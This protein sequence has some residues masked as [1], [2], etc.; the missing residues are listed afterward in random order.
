MATNTSFLTNLRDKFKKGLTTFQNAMLG[1]PVQVMQPESSVQYQYP[2]QR[3]TDFMNNFRNNEDLIKNIK[4]SPHYQG[5]TDDELF[6]RVAQ[7]QNFGLKE[8][9]DEQ[10]QWGIKLPRANNEYD[11][12]ALEG[13]YLNVYQPKLQTGTANEPRQGGIINDFITGARENYN[14]GFNVDNWGQKKNFATRLGEGL[15]TL[16]R[17]ADSAPGRGLIAGG[18][19]GALGGS[20]A[21]MTAY[22]LSAG[23][24]RQQN[25][26]QDQLYRQRLK[27]MGY[28]QD[29]L[30]SI[31]GNVTDDV[32][33]N[34]ANSYKLNNSVK[35][36][37]LAE[38]NPQ[39]KAAIEA[40]PDLA[41]S[42]VPSSVMNQILRMPLTNAQ[43]AKI[44]A[45]TE[46]TTGAKTEETKAKTAKTKEETGQVGKP[47]VSINIKQGGTKSVIEHRGGS[48]GNTKS[49]SATPL[50]MP[51]LSSKNKEKEYLF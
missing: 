42:F 28:T 13:N 39:I 45:D 6:N 29:E 8:L 12:A 36:G 24:G 35:W 25:R 47:K 46:Y 23:V 20:P 44:I 14:Q 37:D 17:F 5:Y 3:Q 40:N 43:I 15:G 21:E 10:K 48:G 32:Y 33:K 19:I 31:R 11:N 22:G 16:A 34:L 27:D 38:F 1:T 50:K 2:T 7:G 41:D 26:M 9:A 18:L 4:A 49:G 30:D 51:S